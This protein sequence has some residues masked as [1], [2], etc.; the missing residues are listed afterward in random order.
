MEFLIATCILVGA[1]LI[2]QLRGIAFGKS[3]KLG[4]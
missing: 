3:P 2:V 4:F 1:A